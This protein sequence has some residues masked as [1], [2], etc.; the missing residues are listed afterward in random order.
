MVVTTAKTGTAGHR[1]T[2][3]GIIINNNNNINT[4]V[5]NNI[6]DNINIII[7]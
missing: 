1:Y 4:I 7:T 6:N 2:P 5:N 3:L